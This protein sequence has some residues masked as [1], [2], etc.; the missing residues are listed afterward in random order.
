MTISTPRLLLFTLEFYPFQG[1][2]ASYNDNLI[3]GLAHMGYRVDVLTSHLSGR[4]KEEEEVDR[5]LVHNG[6]IRIFRKQLYS[7]GKLLQWAFIIPVFIFLFRKPDVILITDDAGQRVASVLQISR[8]RIPYFITVHGSEVYSTFSRETSA[9]GIDRKLFGWFK[10]RAERFFS[11]SNGVIFVSRYTRDLF[12]RLYDKPLKRYKVVHNGIGEHIILSKP[13][14]KKRYETKVG[15]IVCITVSRIDP[16]KNHAAVFKALKLMPDSIRSRVIYKII[17]SGSFR[18]EL[19]ACARRLGLANQ[20]IFLGE[21]SEE[22]KYRELD[23]AD[24][25]IMPSKQVRG[26]VEGLGI[27]F[28]EAAARGLPLIGGRHGGVPEVI[29]DGYN[30]FLVDPDDNREIM[31]ALKKLVENRSLREKMGWNS[32]KRVRAHFSREKMTAATRDFMFRN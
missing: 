2:V 18:I 9:E 13:E 11:K 29:H 5:E 6:R 12:K 20:I 26:T 32:W 27:S 1:G 16:R 23:T 14:V 24:I 25:F 4:S 7:R 31:H 8:F 15:E 28:L 17:G 21:L 10:R 19:E 22:H 30:G 3:R